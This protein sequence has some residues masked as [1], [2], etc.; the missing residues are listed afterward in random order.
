MSVCLT[1]AL[2][3]REWRFRVYVN[4]KGRRAP[5]VRELTEASRLLS[6]TPISGSTK[7]RG[8]LVLSG[9]PIHIR[10]RGDW[11]VYV[12]G[13]GILRPGQIYDGDGKLR[14]NWIGA[15][16]VLALDGKIVPMS[17]AGA[18][19]PDL[20]TGT[21]MIGFRR[22]GTPVFLC[23]VAGTGRSRRPGDGV[24]ETQALNKLLREKCVTVLQF[25]WGWSCCATLRRQ[26]M[27]PG[28]KTS[29][30]L[31]LL[32]YRRTAERKKKPGPAAVDLLGR[33]M[34]QKMRVRETSQEVPVRSAPR[35]PLDGEPDNVVGHLAPGQTV[36]VY[37]LTGKIWGK[38][39]TDRWVNVNLLV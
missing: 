23:A 3:N 28:R 16:R 37:G 22:D 14:E 10:R 11:G 19:L 27:L 35:Y 9:V 30:G 26:W 13:D 31:F 38:I 39:G 15:L 12:D 32:A 17:E 21:T 1:E 4:G 25:G 24:T 36:T 34:I 29:C 6:M 8:G 18:H 7:L 2:P 5:R 33:D 20:R